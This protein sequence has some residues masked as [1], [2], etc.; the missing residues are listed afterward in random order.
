M[1]VRGHYGY[2]ACGRVSNGPRDARA[3]LSLLMS[4]CHAHT[5]SSC[6][7]TQ[8]YDSSNA[9]RRRASISSPIF[10]RVLGTIQTFD[11]A[12]RVAESKRE[13]ETSCVSFACARTGCPKGVVSGDRRITC[14]GRSR[15]DPSDAIEDLNR[16]DLRP[17]FHAYSR[18]PNSV[19]HERATSHYWHYPWRILSCP[20]IRR[21]AWAS[22]P[23]GFDRWT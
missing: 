19:R 14:K 8:S 4:V 10:R 9:M 21:C 15:G 11:L 12:M 3:I 18:F 7:C 2:V 5:H 13:F 23:P 6:F 22:L 20:V 16:H 17:P 1:M